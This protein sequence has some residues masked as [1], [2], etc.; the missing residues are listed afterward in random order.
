MQQSHTVCTEHSGLIERLSNI[1]RQIKRLDDI[2]TAITDLRLSLIEHKTKVST[3][4]KSTA[5]LWSGL[6][7]IL[8]LAVGFFYKQ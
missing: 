2:Y 8:G 3:E 7:T 1:E 5:R 4:A 6:I